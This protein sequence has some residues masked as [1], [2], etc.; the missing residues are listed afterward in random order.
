MSEV[1]NPIPLFPLPEF[2]VP[3]GMSE[4]LNDTK[5]G[6]RIKAS[7]AFEVVEKTEH[8]IIIAIDNI[9]FKNKSKRKFI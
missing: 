6:A 7:V 3:K 9:A 1:F 4:P 5:I 2:D 8:G